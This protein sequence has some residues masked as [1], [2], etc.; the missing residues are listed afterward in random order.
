MFS[1]TTIAVILLSSALSFGQLAFTVS[2]GYSN[3]QATSNVGGQFP[4][5]TS[6][7]RFPKQGEYVDG[8]LAVPIRQ[9]P[10]PLLLGA[11]IS[12]TGHVHSSD[13]FTPLNSLYNNSPTYTLNMHSQFNQY[14]FEA[15]A[16]APIYFA[17]SSDSNGLY[18][19]PRIGVG[20]LYYYYH[21]HHLSG[22]DHFPVIQNGHSGGDAFLVRPA[23]EIGYTWRRISFGVEGSSMFAW[24]KF[25]PFGGNEREL[26][27]GGFVS[28]RF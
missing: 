18:I 3:A 15:R 19:M 5:Y 2:G 11:G 13:P 21:G 1:R 14:A 7:F 17:G 28:Y 6:A 26:R 9:A 24:G 4:F 16:A 23:L 8:D 27:A 12:W 20:G 22:I 25:A 10:F